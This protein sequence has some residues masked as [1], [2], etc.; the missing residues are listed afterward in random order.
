MLCVCVYRYMKVNFPLKTGIEEPISLV[1]EG[2]LG[3]SF[4]TKEP[5]N[6]ATITKG[7]HKGKF[8][9]N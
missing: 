4:Y 1:S 3:G 2:D 7:L 5:K 8:N 6:E 9:C